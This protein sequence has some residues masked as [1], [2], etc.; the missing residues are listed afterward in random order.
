MIDDKEK[1][2]PMSYTLNPWDSSRIPNLI[3]EAVLDSIGAVQQVREIEAVLGKWL[4]DTKGI[5]I[6]GKTGDYQVMDTKKNEDIYHSASYTAC[7]E[8]A[9]RYEPKPKVEKPE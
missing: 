1:F 7:L 2:V 4:A 9:L 3:H 6:W 8:F 5:W